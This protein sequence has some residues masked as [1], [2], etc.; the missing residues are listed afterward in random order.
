MICYIK[1]KG[2]ELLDEGVN[3]KGVAKAVGTNQALTSVSVVVGLGMVAGGISL[4]MV[5]LVAAIRYALITVMSFA[6]IS[7][8]DAYFKTPPHHV[9]L[10]VLLLKKAYHE[11]DTDVQSTM[12]QYV[13]LADE[14]YNIFFNTL[15]GAVK[16]N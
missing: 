2:E 16:V 13:D 4:P 1:K 10:S 5:A 6:A 11:A 9:C 8:A 7:S 12:K 3:F 14:R 15:S